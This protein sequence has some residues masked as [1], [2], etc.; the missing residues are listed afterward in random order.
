MY[1]FCGLE[2]KEFRSCRDGEKLEDTVV[3]GG[4]RCI[5]MYGRL[6]LVMFT[7]YVKFGDIVSEAF[8]EGM[9][10]R[11]WVLNVISE[12]N[13]LPGLKIAFNPPLHFSFITTDFNEPQL[14]ITD[15]N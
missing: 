11:G 14:T 9:Q 15:T 7:F 3:E 10:L 1:V 6:L 13:S 4:R 5:W 12:A 2:R 8:W